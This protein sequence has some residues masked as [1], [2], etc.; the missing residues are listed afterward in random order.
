M[1]QSK[2]SSFKKVLANNTFAIPV[3]T[4]TMRIIDQTIEEI[5]E[6]NVRTRKLLTT[7]G[8]FHPNGDVD[9]LYLPRS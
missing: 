1:W 4:T 6:I 8:N 7:A 9:K 3:F 2:L 5:K